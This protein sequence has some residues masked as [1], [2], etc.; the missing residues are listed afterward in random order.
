MCFGNDDVLNSEILMHLNII[1]Y[2]VVK[3]EQQESQK[4][5]Q[6]RN[7]KRN[8]RRQ[9]KRKPKT[10]EQKR[11]TQM[12]RTLMQNKYGKLFCQFL[13]QQDVHIEKGCA[14]FMIYDNRQHLSD[15]VKHAECFGLYT[16][17]IK[18][19]RTGNMNIQDLDQYNIEIPQNSNELTAAIICISKKEDLSDLQVIETLFLQPK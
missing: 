4:Q 9:R 3:T 1:Y 10:E 18:G 15:W 19:F 14:K 16:K 8:Q 13:L 5:I 7:Q 12:T 11:E 2:M 17:N 6:K